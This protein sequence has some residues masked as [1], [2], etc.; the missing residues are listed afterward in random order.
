MIFWFLS[1]L[2]GLLIQILLS[3]FTLTIIVNSDP[4]KSLRQIFFVIF[5]WFWEPS[6]PST[7]IAFANELK[8]QN[9]VTGT[10]NNSVSFPLSFV[11]I[12]ILTMPQ[13]CSLSLALTCLNSWTEFFL[14]NLIATW[15]RRKIKNQII[16]VILKWRGQYLFQFSLLPVSSLEITCYSEHFLENLYTLLSLDGV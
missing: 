14:T 16:I 5:S 8:L 13:L 12:T 2:S 4:C 10:G 15:R 11:K 9:H 7:E 1:I 6:L 3:K